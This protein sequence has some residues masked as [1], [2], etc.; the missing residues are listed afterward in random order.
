M[1]H[2]E[3]VSPGGC[4]DLEWWRRASPEKGWV[5]LY[6]SEEVFAENTAEWV[7]VLRKAGVEGVREVIE[8]GGIHAWVIARAFL[9]ET[10]E[11]RGQGIEE[12]A[13]EVWKRLG[14]GI[15]AEEGEVKSSSDRL[16]SG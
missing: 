11:E 13:G 12:I 10:T 2:D 3:L 5:V 4:K 9:G 6:G 8:E 1:V 7:N 16:M 15:G 14:A